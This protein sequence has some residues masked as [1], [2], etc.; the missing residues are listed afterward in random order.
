MVGQEKE[1]LV[2]GIKGDI[3]KKWQKFLNLRGTN[4]NLMKTHLK[5]QI[6][7]TF[8]EKNDKYDLR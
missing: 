4:K 1:K 3:I 5:T 6:K 8:L 2:I 7:W